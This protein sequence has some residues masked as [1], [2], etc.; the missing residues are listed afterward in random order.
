M[1]GS[2]GGFHRGG[3]LRLHA[4]D[5]YVGVEELCQGGNAGSQSAAA[6]GHQDHVHVGEILE[7]L[8]GNGALTSGYGQVVKGVNIGQPLLLREPRSLCGGLVKAVP[9]NDHVGAV[10]LGVVDLHQGG[11]G[12]HDNG[13]GDAGPLGGKGH[14]LGVVS[15][16]GRDQTPGF[17]LVG[18]GGDL[19]AG[20]PDLIGS[21]ELHI[22][23]L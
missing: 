15:G 11:G 1:T 20:A 5:L 3:A 19:E 22:F 10:G 8:V 7:N 9:V 17:F 4:D 16:G 23:R 18:E 6:D 2:Q 12:G 13:G 21:G 14:P